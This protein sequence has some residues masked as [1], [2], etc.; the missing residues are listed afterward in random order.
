MK[1]RRSIID[2]I[3]PEEAPTGPDFRKR[4]KWWMLL[5]LVV[6]AL[7]LGAT[8]FVHLT[9]S[10]SFFVHPAIAL[11]VLIGTTF[12]LSLL[13]ALSLPLI[14]NLLGFSYVQ[15]M[16]DVAYYTVLVYFTGGV[17]SAFSLIYIFPIIAAGLLD[18]RRG[19][20][21]TASAASIL[22]GLL[23]SLQLHG[24]LPTSEWPWVMPW[25]SQTPRYVLWVLVV[26]FT[27][28]FLAAFLSSSVAEQLRTTKVSLKLKQTD[29]EK[30]AD[31][32]SSIVRSIPSGIVTTDWSDRI[33]FVN[34]AGMKLLGASSA[35][36]V[37]LPLSQVFPVIDD[38]LS[39][40]AVRLVTYG[41]T[42]EVRG[43]KLQLDLTVSDL[44]IRDGV[45]GGRLII[46]QDV[47]RLKKMEE[48]VKISERQAAFV[49]VAAGMG[50]EIRNPLAALRGAA[51][52][53][54]QLDPRYPN[55]KKLL[56]IITRESDRLNTLLGQFLFTIM[57]TPL[58]K[59]RV[60]LNDL[61]EETVGQ[62]SKGE[63]VRG[64]LSLETL[65][66]KGVEVEGDPS[67]LKQAIWNLL[68]NA[69]EASPQSG[70]VRVILL[71]DEQEQKAIL[72]VQ[73]SGPGIP[74]EIRDRIFEPFA[75][76]RE[77]RLGLGLPTVLSIVEA[78]NGTIHLEDVPTGGTVFV[79]RLPMASGET[80]VMDMEHGDGPETP[81]SR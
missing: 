74:P 53:L 24:I 76:G 57:P 65:V 75:T 46:F 31:L 62:F 11:Y 15:V 12:L 43:E 33:T 34:S 18:F 58:R 17:S 59:V 1:S 28:F 23:I 48:R 2:M 52:L 44:V 29:Y 5:R 78:H 13:Y 30:L 8:I 9:Q 81:H 40:S 36:L 42:K 72:R 60:M 51:E 77:G 56:H 37:G 80:L 63:A 71:T 16:V 47:T 55:E 22:F 70:V 64:R 26:H 68:A 27:V 39:K 7:L 66:N 45:P 32:H 4:V 67:R 50:H 54:S 10:G 69:F 49:R 73:D 20:F 41:T 6:T 3:L 35:E 38:G 21:A 25:T 14:T 79:I 19:A 61:V